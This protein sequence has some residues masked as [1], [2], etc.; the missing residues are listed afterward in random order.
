MWWS[1]IGQN[2]VLSVLSPHRPLLLLL[3]LWPFNF[4]PAVPSQTNHKGPSSSTQISLASSRMLLSRNAGAAVGSRHCLLL[5][6]SAALQRQV[7]CSAKRG[8]PSKSREDVELG[9]IEPEP[10]PAKR[11]GRKGNTEVQP[12][13]TAAEAP[14]TQQMQPVAVRLKGMLGKYTCLSR[15]LTA[16]VGLLSLCC[17]MTGCFCRPRQGW[18][19]AALSGLQQPSWLARTQRCGLLSLLTGHGQ[20]SVSLGSGWQ[21]ALAVHGVPGW[22]CDHHSPHPLAH[23][24]AV[25]ACTCTFCRP[26]P[27]QD[28]ERVISIEDMTSSVELDY[29]DNPALIVPSY[30]HQARP[31][32]CD[33]C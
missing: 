4:L 5:P 14:L 20:L 33:C 22:L 11:K 1:C 7:R 8:R 31:P 24:T 17:S 16:A 25:A 6:Q 2:Y 12:A 23:R 13:P 3:L 26:C 30:T 28:H 32:C 29:T 10:A 9:S 15:G 19:A 21:R 18:R 27:L